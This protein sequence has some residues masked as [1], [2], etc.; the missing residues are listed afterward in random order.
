MGISVIHIVLI[1]FFAVLVI[2]LD[3]AAFV[4]IARLH[5]VTGRVILWAVLILLFPVVGALAVLFAAPRT[6][7][8]A[9]D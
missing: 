3:V 2:G 9:A 6:P 8:R 1:L 4:R 7:R 5:E